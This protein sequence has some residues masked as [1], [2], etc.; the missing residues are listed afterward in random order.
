[1][2]YDYRFSFDS[3]LSAWTEVDM[4]K[5]THPYPAAECLQWCFWITVARTS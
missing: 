5:S 4:V 2:T 3:P 1:M